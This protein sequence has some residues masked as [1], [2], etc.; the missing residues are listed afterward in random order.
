[1]L[2]RQKWVSP[3]LSP[4]GWQK[5]WGVCVWIL[6]FRI[7]ALWAFSC[8]LLTHMYHASLPSV[9]L[10]SG[11]LGR[12]AFMES[13]KVVVRVYIPANGVWCQHFLTLL[14]LAVFPAV[15][16]STT[17]PTDTKAGNFPASLRFFSS[18]LSKIINRN[19]QSSEMSRSLFSV[20]SPQMSWS[21]EL[22]FSSNN[23]EGLIRI[24]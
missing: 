17:V 16:S 20:L 5:M 9:F 1:M 8:V 3:S 6:L 2:R 18:A 22:N 19:G 11:L 12:P 10:G 14:G 13:V 23:Y 15:V 24:T 4:C 7:M 21:G